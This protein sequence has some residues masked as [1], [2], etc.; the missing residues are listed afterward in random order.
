MGKCPWN[1]LGGML[2]YE[3]DHMPGLGIVLKKDG[4]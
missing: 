1:R 2:Y 3:L 4:H